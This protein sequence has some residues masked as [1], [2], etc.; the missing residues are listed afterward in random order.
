MAETWKQK[1]LFTLLVGDAVV[2]VAGTLIGFATHGE[3][4]SAGLRMLTTLLP[5]SAA[6]FAAALP[7][8]LFAPAVTAQGREL[9]RVWSACLFAAPL[10]AVLRALWLG[11]TVLPV[12]VV[13]MFL[14]FGTLFFGWRALFWYW[15]KK[16]HI[17]G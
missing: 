2:L 11:S 4:A 15:Q 10:A 13:I 1:P 12:F 14:S 9:W 17:H 6:W 5:M 8:Q 16:I 3:L 7:L